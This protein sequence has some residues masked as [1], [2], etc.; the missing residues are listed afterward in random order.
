MGDPTVNL[1]GMAVPIKYLSLLVLVVQNTSLVLLMRY[2]RTVDGPMYI[3]STA[4][5]MAEVMKLATCLAIIVKEQG[6]ISGLVRTLQDDIIGKPPGDA[7]GW[8]PG[9]AVH[10]PE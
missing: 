6:G 7:H 5:V 1:L 9:A 4:V 3:S 2:S 10:H 8:R